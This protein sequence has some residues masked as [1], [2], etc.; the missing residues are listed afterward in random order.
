[1]IARAILLAAVVV[2]VQ[3][4]LDTA[5]LRKEVD[6]NTHS[7][8]TDAEKK[9][10][11]DLTHRLSQAVA[12]E[13]LG[14][15]AKSFLEMK[16]PKETDEEPRLK[17]RVLTGGFGL[18]NKP[19]KNLAILRKDNEKFG[20]QDELEEIFKKLTAAINERVS[21]F[22]DFWRW[23]GKSAGADPDFDK[24]LL[25]VKEDLIP[26]FRVKWKDEI[27]D[28]EY[29]ESEVQRDMKQRHFDL[30]GSIGSEFSAMRIKMAEKEKPILTKMAAY[31]DEIENLVSSE[32]DNYVN[33]IEQYDTKFE[34]L[35][36]D[37]GKMV[38]EDVA[39]NKASWREVKSGLGGMRM[40]MMGFDQKME[41][42][43]RTL[44]QEVQKA[45][46]SLND[47]YMNR[48]KQFS[49]E[50]KNFEK[51]ANRLTKIGNKDTA[52]S[53][54]KASKEI[55]AFMKEATAEL[56][57][58]KSNAADVV[59]N[60]LKDATSEAAV[61]SKKLTAL[62]DASKMLD[63][64]GRLMYKRSQ[65]SAKEAATK[66][67]DSEKK[68]ADT[69]T[70]VKAREAQTMDSVRAG[71]DR[72]EQEMEAQA[73]ESSKS[74]P[75][76]ASTL[77]VT[78][79]A[80]VGEEQ[81]AADDVIKKINKGWADQDEEF[82][83]RET[84]KVAA[85]LD[86]TNTNIANTF[87]ETLDPV[88]AIV[89]NSMKTQR[90]ELDENTIALQ[91]KVDDVFMDLPTTIMNSLT[92]AD[93]T[94]TGMNEAIL[95]G[96]Q[97]L[98]NDL[99][100]KEEAVEDDMK[101][102]LTSKQDE[103]KQFALSTEPMI[104]SAKEKLNTLGDD[105]KTISND[106][107]PSLRDEMTLLSG[108]LN[109]K[110]TIF[111][112]D[113][114]KETD[115]M[116]NGVN[117]EVTQEVKAVSKAGQKTMDTGLHAIEEQDNIV[118]SARDKTTVKVD[119][120]KKD[121]KSKETQTLHEDATEKDQM[122]DINA[123]WTSTKDMAKNRIAKL[124]ADVEQ[125]KATTT[126][127]TQDRKLMVNSA[128]DLLVAKV[129]ASLAGRLGKLHDDR[130]ALLAKVD[131]KIKQIQDTYAKALETADAKAAEAQR[132]INDKLSTFDGVMGTLTSDFDSEELA[133]TSLADELHGKV[134]AA[135]DEFSADAI[136]AAT[137][138]K[139]K[140]ATL[141]KRTTYL[142]S[143]ISSALKGANDDLK[144]KLN[145]AVEESHKRMK[146]IMND[147]SKTE[148]QQL[149]AFREEEARLQRELKSV[150]QREGTMST[151]MNDL[152]E[153]TS[154]ASDEAASKMA[155][156]GGDVAG[157]IA[158]AKAAKA[159]STLEENQ[160]LGGSVDQATVM[161]N[162]INGLEGSVG[163]MHSGLQSRW[164]RQQAHMH[165]RVDTIKQD[166]VT[167]VDKLQ[168][169]TKR[170]EA[171]TKEGFEDMHDD[172]KQ[173]KRLIT[174][175]KFNV[176]NELEG[177]DNQLGVL[178]GD[179][180]KS[181]GGVQRTVEVSVQGIADEL[182]PMTMKMEALVDDAG[183]KD[184][185]R[186]V[187]Q[188]QFASALFKIEQMETDA[189]QEDA[190]AL[191]RAI[192]LLDLKHHDL[193]SDQHGFAARDKAWKQLVFEKMK[194]L[195][196]E[197][198]N[199]AMTALHGQ[200][201][202]EDMWADGQAKEES[203]V[204]A[205]ARKQQEEIDA[206]IAALYAD[207]D[208]AIAKIRNNA[209]MSEEEKAAAIAQ[210]EANT[211]AQMSKVYAEQA[212]AQQKQYEINMALDKYHAMV[213]KAKAAAEA[214]VASGL[215]S[216]EAMEIHQHLSNVT[217]KI[218]QMRVQ[219]WTKGSVLELN[220]QQALMEHA[221]SL[222]AHALVQM[223][224]TKKTENGEDSDCEQCVTELSDTNDQLK[225]ANGK[226][227]SQL[228]ALEAK[229]AAAKKKKA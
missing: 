44:D 67:T 90:K 65:E 160:E 7:A 140:T 228:A 30:F 151:Q 95:E 159:K 49:K 74:I 130:I 35:T 31:R 199:S 166:A 196:V 227:S 10:D 93:E 215:M 70:A 99:T 91:G 76:Y 197:I 211:K 108:E 83:E 198:D 123:Q 9:I 78:M 100:H 14:D 182:T 72:S 178:V 102:G 136:A 176:N 126:K 161:M 221:S 94:R 89:K 194:K 186:A 172:A 80:D 212:E 137:S 73:E 144:E 38:L 71:I 134:K 96:K 124:S 85:Q 107:V 77:R 193:A 120:M 84:D 51:A 195:G 53:K 47:A 56:K 218:E 119:S 206:K 101:N 129:G 36:Q 125:V 154:T 1:M 48:K 42:I 21:P 183:N 92:S 222:S 19:E 146:A 58:K 27:G 82:Q 54:K 57:D 106:E 180:L 208:A 29:A 32:Y 43:M 22:V 18:W 5:T 216:P 171:S 220:G 15:S 174:D 139:E 153:Q 173:M 214:A 133:S 152:I 111:Q 114:H 175:T 209:H 143:K 118:D 156:A 192:R 203:A 148:A 205:A 185:D 60:L 39:R 113:V 41:G 16:P 219:S 116:I 104:D 132:A 181:V 64:K 157:G 127:S 155:G 162:I 169:D 167:G 229:L 20:S 164:E 200:Q 168:A 26:N 12:V 45:G 225:S 217:E 61:T 149:Q 179:T 6:A 158:A 50:T 145:G 34:Q 79:K 115:E 224:D 138:D 68:L 69:V 122:R 213:D 187:K 66:V 24:M 177:V 81:R 59:E 23:Q 117:E 28:Y 40:W 46:G 207:S 190:D 110:R 210:I 3:I 226:L 184:A 55:A 128:Q 98:R 135:E 97:S 105:I 13:L 11:A 141:N 63:T 2:A 52:R 87:K 112:D 189:S 202:A 75:A 223:E 201:E 121:Y 62:E 150:N 86:E 103:L 33:G 191:T 37:T 17:E 109:K 88:S 8:T 170:A 163:D 142:K 204:D 131:D 188:G 165:K 25:Q 147:S 4:E